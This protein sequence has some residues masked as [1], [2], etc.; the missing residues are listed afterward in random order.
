MHKKV[1]DSILASIDDSKKTVKLKS[2]LAGNYMNTIRSIKKDMLDN[3]NL[4]VWD[5][6]RP[7]PENQRLISEYRQDQV[8][9]L[10]QMGGGKKEFD[11]MIEL[12]RNLNNIYVNY[13]IDKVIDVMRMS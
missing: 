10:R 8:N 9:K 13:V 2:S 7:I 4:R 11:Y 5:G 3:F 12:Y 1:I 6:L